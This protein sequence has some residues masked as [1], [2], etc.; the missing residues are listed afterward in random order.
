MADE[1]ASGKQSSQRNWVS[2]IPFG[3]HQQHPN[4]YKDILDAAWENRDSL[5]YAYHHLGN[6]THAITS[7]LQA[8]ALFGDLGHRYNQADTLTHLGDTHH[9]VGNH[10]AAHDAWQQAL[11]ILDDL[12][13]PD[14][15]Q[16]RTKLA[17]LDGGVR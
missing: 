15:G 2:L 7:Y 3:L 17:G 9:A 8:L 11:I 1:H 4:N 13:H 6:H 10:Q 5:G 12:H 14:A 16:L